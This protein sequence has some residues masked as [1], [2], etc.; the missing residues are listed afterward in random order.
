MKLRLEKHRW[1]NNS[2]L[3]LTPPSR[4]MRHGLP[5]IVKAESPIRQLRVCSNEVGM[6]KDALD[7]RYEQRTC[8]WKRLSAYSSCNLITV[9]AWLKPQLSYRL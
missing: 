7:S 1:A 9:I 5:G 6:G 2:R 8:S 4:R 3:F